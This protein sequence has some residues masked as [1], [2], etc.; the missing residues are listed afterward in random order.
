MNTLAPTT[1]DAP[2]ENMTV[3]SE[4]DPQS[5]G[6]RLARSYEEGKKITL[7]GVG[8]YAVNTMVKATIIANGNMAPRGVV[9]LLFPMFCS[10]KNMK[11]EEGTDSPDVI[12][13]V[14]FTV[15]PHK[16]V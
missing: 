8:A 16:V 3:G 10:V 7:T 14:T 9:F 11:Q 6:W 13:A 1:D 2:H 4:T 12:T 5:L 15:V